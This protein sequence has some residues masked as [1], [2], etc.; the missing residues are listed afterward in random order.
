M[1]STEGFWKGLYV[2]N[3]EERSYLSNLEI[4]NLNALEDDLLRLTGGINFYKA[5]V[6]IKNVLIENVKAEDASSVIAGYMIANDVS[7]RDWQLHSAT[8][9]IGKSFD[10]HG[11]IGPALVTPDEIEDPH[12]VDIRLYV[13]DEI[14]QD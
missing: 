3:A 8:W 9:T 13:N 2:W 6:D 11:P 4:K 7:V 12:N 14:R 5:D 1:E 10:T